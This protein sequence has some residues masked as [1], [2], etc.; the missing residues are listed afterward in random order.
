[1]PRGGPGPRPNGHV[2]IYFSSSSQSAVWQKMVIASSSICLSVASKSSSPIC[3]LS[4]NNK[5][6]LPKYSAY[7]KQYHV[8]MNKP[9]DNE[10]LR[11]FRKQ[12]IPQANGCTLWMGQ[13]GTKDGYGKFLPHP[14]GT[15]VVAHR[16][17]YEVHN[18]PIPEGM[19]VDHRCHS[20]DLSC[21]GGPD[22]IH[23]RCCNPAHLELVT[24]SENTMR[25]RHHERSVTHCPQG[26]EYSGDNLIVRKDGKRRCRECD[27]ARKR[28]SHSVTPAS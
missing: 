24:P 26:H 8:G 9:P 16:W 17:I 13:R 18:G 7:V 14:G 3:P 25:Q 19:Q 21:P 15:T 22:C 6:I 5:T 11:K 10:Q 2:S 4:L 12:A 23:R 20:D 28:S 27:R 1:M